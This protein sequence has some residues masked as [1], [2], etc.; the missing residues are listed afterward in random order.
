MHVERSSKRRKEANPG[1]G[2]VGEVAK[3]CELASDSRQLFAE[4]G[5]R[6]GSAE[7]GLEVFDG[8]PETH[9][10]GR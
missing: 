5:W 8:L 3:I 1:D 4:I 6:L 7:G 10:C 2:I 9:D